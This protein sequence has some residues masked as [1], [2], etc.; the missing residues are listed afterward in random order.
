MS[1]NFPLIRAETFEPYKNQKGGISYKAE[2]LPRDAYDKTQLK[3]LEKNGIY[4]KI[5]PVG[6]G[7]CTG[8]LLDYSRDKATQ[9]MM[10][11]AFGNNGKAYPE[12]Q[13]WFI[14]CTY[15]DEYLPTHTY[16]RVDT[17]EKCEGISLSVED[18]Q[19]F[20]KRLRNHFPN[21]KI[22]YVVAG[23]YGS[24]TLRPHY[25]FIMFGLP[26]D[27]TQFKTA[28]Q[29][30]LGQRTWKS[31]ELEKI[32]GMGYCEIG[33]VDWRSCAYVARYTLKKAFKKDKWWYLSQ[34]MQPEFIAW[35]N[36]IG[37]NFIQEKIESKE[38]LEQWYTRGKVPIS[39]HM[40]GLLKIPK[41]YDRIIKEIDPKLYDKISRMRQKQAHSSELILRRQTDLTP[42]ERRTMQEARMKQVM[43]DIRT[44]V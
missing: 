11:K 38:E 18:E 37:K 34:G 3:M 41:S 24:K 23:E 12:E 13:C 15:S 14:T 44:E 16:V 2:F 9:M 26:L 25:H 40:G 27:Q 42:E 10:E 21:S 20:M 35:S 17:G 19:K 31:E 1:C 39:S 43:K 29:N 30:E 5:T 22:K 36:G 4:R 33:R 6:C 32:W 8:C 28:H 7:Q